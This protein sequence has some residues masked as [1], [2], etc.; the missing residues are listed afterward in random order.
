M[1]GRDVEG[2]GTYLVLD[3]YSPKA[4]EELKGCDDMAL[5]QHR[6]CDR[7]CRPPSR[8]DW[9]FVKPLLQW[10]LA[11]SSSPRSSPAEHVVHI[12]ACNAYENR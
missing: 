12:H 2:A 7:S 8:A 3:K 9:H 1:M 5:H 11:Y 10:E 6:C 4:I